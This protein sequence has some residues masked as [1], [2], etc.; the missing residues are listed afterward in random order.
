LLL[1]LLKTPWIQIGIHNWLEKYFIVATKA[2]SSATFGVG[3]LE[4]GRIVN[5]GSYEEVLGGR[6]GQAH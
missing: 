3:R 1:S 6:A 2:S 5:V 4:N